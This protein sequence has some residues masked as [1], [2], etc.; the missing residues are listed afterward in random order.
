MKNERNFYQV[1][2][3]LKTELYI[4]T[5]KW[6][7]HINGEERVVTLPTVS[8]FCEDMVL[9]LHSF[10]PEEILSLEIKPNN[11]IVE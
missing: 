8:Y 6:R 5:N 9:A 10:K 3:R 11:F 1:T 7:C 2:I 4:D